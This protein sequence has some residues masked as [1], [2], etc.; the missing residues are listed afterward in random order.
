MTA[1]RPPRQGGVG[2]LLLHAFA[3]AV[4]VFLLLPT[5]LVA[6]MSVS[7]EKYLQFPP[8]GFSLRWYGEY[9]A[10]REWVEATLFSAEA[11]IISAIGATVVG[12]MTALALVRGRV[13]GRAVVELLIIGPV[14]VPHI[15]LAVAMF[16]VYEQ[17]RLTGTLLGF[18]M[19]HIVL[20]LPFAIFT[21]LAALYR[22]DADL[23]MAALSCG[24]SR[25]ATFRHVTLPMIAPGVASAALFAFIIS[26]DEAVVSFFISDLDRK[27]LP[28]K[29][30]EDIDFDVSPVLA[31]VATMLSLL[32]ILVLVLGHFFKQMADRRAAP[33]REGKTP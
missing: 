6:P 31:A 19:A 23:E 4:I 20:A 10:D 14:V 1:G 32:T 2:R 28:R 7:P 5:V 15:A 27:T 29:M 17:L 33:A 11:G 30:F 8:S 25:I 21:V 9:F 24:A 18:A 22:F 16:L 26:F 3:Y 12:T 13:R